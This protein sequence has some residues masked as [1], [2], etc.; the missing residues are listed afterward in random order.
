MSVE[1]VLFVLRV[2]FIFALYF[3]I[4]MVARVLSKELNTPVDVAAPSSAAV[5]PKGRGAAIPGRA[6]LVVVDGAESGILSGTAL[7]VQAGTLIGRAG[8]SD[9]QLAD[10]YTSSEHARI[11][12]AGEQWMLEDLDSM[13]GSYI[14]GQRMRGAQQLADGDTVQLGRIVLQ[15]VLRPPA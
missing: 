4:L 2:V 15:F 9:I 13:N 5:R 6:Y 11:R 14:N 12:Q 8:G 10:A 7:A 3:F 1:Y